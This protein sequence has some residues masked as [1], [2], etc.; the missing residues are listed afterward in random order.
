MSAHTPGP[1]RVGDAGKTVFG[2]KGGLPPQG[3]A[4][5]YAQ[6]TPGESHANARLIAQAPAMLEALHDLLDTRSPSTPRSFRV[7]SAEAKARSILA[8][9]EGK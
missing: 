7:R 5:M 9:I 2:P 6:K 8:T 1:W 4:G 3:I